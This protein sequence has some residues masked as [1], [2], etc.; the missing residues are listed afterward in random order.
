MRSLRV[1]PWAL[2][3][4]PFVASAAPAE[5]QA[6]RGTALEC[7]LPVVV[8]AGVRD[9]HESWFNGPEGYGFIVEMGAEKVGTLPVAVGREPT[10]HFDTTVYASNFQGPDLVL[11]P[12]LRPQWEWTA[13]GEAQVSDRTYALLAARACA[14]SAAALP[15]RILHVAE[16]DE[17]PLANDPVGA[18]TVELGRCQEVLSPTRASG[19]S[20][21]QHSLGEGYGE[22]GSARDV[23]FVDYVLWCYRCDKGDDCED[24]IVWHSPASDQE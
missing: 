7:A 22:S 8:R 11:R 15:A 18:F 16:H 24:G 12:G 20:T 23:R 2:L 9:I 1:A 5:P 14:G 21:A 13:A 19:W 17:W 3:V 6:Q 4:L 10:R